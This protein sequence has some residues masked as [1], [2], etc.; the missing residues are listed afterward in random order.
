[1]KNAN[2]GWLFYREYFRGFTYPEV[3]ENDSQ[4]KKK[5]N[6]RTEKFFALKDRL[7]YDFEL[8]KYA[9][10]TSYTR[11]PENR[12]A[13]FELVTDYP[14]MLIGSGYTHDIAAVGATKMGFYFDHTTGLPTIPGS[15]VKGILRSAFPGRD[16]EATRAENQQIAEGKMVYLKEVLTEA[17]IDKA[18]ANDD[19]VIALEKQLFEGTLPDGNQVPMPDRFVCHDA[20]VVGTNGGLMGPD[21][22][23]PHKKPATGEPNPI[24]LLKVLPGVR[25]RF[26]FQLPQVVIGETTISS[27]LL[28]KLVKRVLLDLG[29]GAKTN[30]GYG[31]L[32]DPTAAPPKIPRA[33]TESKGASSGGSSTAPSTDLAIFKPTPDKWYPANSLNP[34]R[35]P[36]VNAKV[37]KKLS[38]R[39]VEVQLLILG[40]ADKSPVKCELKIFVGE[41]PANGQWVKVEIKS[42]AGKKAAAKD[43]LLK[44][45]YYELIGKS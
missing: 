41:L 35:P 43:F 10:K 24:Q 37:L 9:D 3:P 34:K 20:V 21:F 7:L 27:V 14:G 13:G 2:L 6:E 11:L 38:D 23:T 12:F 31:Q 40:L 28:Q 5:V 39:S 15:S 42:F 1:M 32:T 30:V 36:K 25:F 44:D 19:F 29:V 8:N 33:V 18:T 16:R 26:T 17:G 4:E 45:N 22:I